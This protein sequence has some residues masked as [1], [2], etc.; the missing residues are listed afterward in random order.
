MGKLRLNLCKDH[1]GNLC[2]RDQKLLIWWP[3]LLKK[4]LERCKGDISLENE[5]NEEYELIML[6][7][8]GWL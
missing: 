7:L 4:D 1:N 2:L 6:L 5:I 8:L 3:H